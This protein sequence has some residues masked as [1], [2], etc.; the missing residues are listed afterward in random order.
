VIADRYCSAKDPVYWVILAAGLALRFYLASVST[1]LWDE[2]REWI[3]VAESISFEPGS[4]NLPIRGEFHPTL[5]AY[6]MKAGSLLLGRNQLGFRLF[7]LLVGGLTIALAFRLALEW[8]GPTAARWA[9]ALV[10]FNEYHIGTSSM[11]VE[12]SFQ[13]FFILLAVFAFSRALLREKPQYLY[14]AGAASGLAFLCNETSALLPPVFLVVLLLRQRVWLRR[15]EAYLALLIFVGVIWPDLQW[16]LLSSGK[17]EVTYADNLTRIGGIGFTPHYFLFYGRGL[18]RPVFRALGWRLVDSAAEY[19]AMNP[20]FGALLLGAFAFTA[21]RYRR[22]D[23]VQ[24]FLVLLFGLVFVFFLLVRPG[25]PRRRLDPFLWLWVDMTLLPAVLLA[26]SLLADA[27][28][29]WRLWLCLATGIAVFGAVAGVALYHLRMPSH[30]VA[31]IPESVWPAKGQM[32][33]VKAK[34]SSCVLCGSDLQVELRDIRVSHPTGTSESVLNTSDVEDAAVGTD[35]R[36]FRLRA[37]FDP[38]RRGRRYEITYRINRGGPR[39]Q[40]LQGTVRIL[41]DPFLKW[42]ERFWAR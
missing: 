9:A 4:L 32:V 24:K 37:D 38:D 15:K 14:L 23:D 42:P 6:F 41:P 40:L 26:G 16:H 27:Q 36:E 1:Y 17:S 18:I 10:A 13:L 39:N 31:F 7:N 35:D 19:P 20:L 3:P 5:P 29:K 8:K 12:K 28:R 22:G 30:T 21:V 33:D 2:E 11:A 25:A 34:F